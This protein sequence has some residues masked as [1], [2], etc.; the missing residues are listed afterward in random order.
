MEFNIG[1]RVYVRANS[2]EMQSPLFQAID[3]ASAK[4]T[5]V[6]NTTYE[7]DVK[8]IEVTLDNPVDV[9]GQQM[10]VIPGL[11]IDNIE[12]ADGKSKRPMN[13]KKKNESRMWGRPHLTFAA[14]NE[15]VSE[16]SWYFG[17]A[18]CHGIDSF[19][20]EPV[21]DVANDMDTLFDLGLMP[22]DSAND[23]AKREYNK[24]VGMLKARAHANAQRWPVIYRAKLDKNTIDM[25]EDLIDDGDYENALRIIQNNSE[26]VQVAR[27]LGGN[28][29][30]RW[31]MIPNPDLDPINGG[32]TESPE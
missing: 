24:Q 6:Y 5:E 29:E 19:I 7:P 27:G 1:D 21:M 12:K 30:R 22:T 8:R 20:K 9:D 4:I 15:S 3:G 17:L 14:F 28:P 32:S 10:T 26:S 2:E 23:P 25:I 13:N 11:Y 16:P 18:D 31:K